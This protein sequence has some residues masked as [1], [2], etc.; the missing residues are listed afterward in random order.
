M[1]AYGNTNQ[2]SK[3]AQEMD[4][5]GNSVSIADGDTTSTTADHTD[6]GGAD[7]ST[8]TVDRT[9]TITN[10]GSLALNLTGTPVVAVGGTDAGD[11][12]V[13]A[14]P[15][16]PIASSGGTTTFTVRFDPSAVGARTATISITNNDSDENPYDFMIQGTGTAPEMNLKQGT[17]NIPDGGS[18]GFGSHLVNTDTDVT[19]TIE[20]TGAADL[21]LTILPI[22]VGGADAGQFSIQTQPVSPVTASGNTTFTVRFT[23]T[24][25]GTKT[26][27]ISIVNDDSD[28]NPYDLT[29][30]GTGIA[31][32]ITS[33]SPSSGYPGNS[34]SVTINGTNLSGATT[35]NFGSGITTNSFTV[36]S[37]TQ[38]TATIDISGSAVPGTRD[39]SVTTPGGTAT[40][41]GGFSVL[42]VVTYDEPS[43]YLKIN[44]LGTSQSFSTSHSGKVRQTVEITSTDG[45]LT[46][47][48]PKGTVARQ[49]NGNRLTT[50]G[51]S[52]KENP[53]PP[54][55]NS[56]II[57]LTYDFEP[58]GAT[59]DPPITLTFTYDPETLPEGVEEEDLV[60]AFYDEDTGSWIE[61]E[62][63]VDTDNHTITAL[64]S[65]FTNFAIIGKVIPPAAFTV[66]NL[67]V[68][69]EQIAPGE[70]VIITVSVANTGGMEGSYTAILE[71]NGVREETQSISIAAGG[72][73]RVDFTVSREEP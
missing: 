28:E 2:A 22:T 36:G 72:T 32:G 3:M 23:P 67:T 46:V 5:Y 53:P 38:I 9:F 51:V 55:E 63:V 37:S 52:V 44:L 18:Y 48:I 56:N 64:V 34:F 65:H 47:T 57:G 13:T 12:A 71:V 6:F 8:G 24:P 27:T 35:V 58:D 62:C 21:N 15:S 66:S 33:A 16:T 54:P 43:Y 69:P 17:T 11:F 50:F 49:E 26:A 59:F 42:E 39:I 4:V 70:V 45:L 1:G 19:F 30:T 40:L 60:L 29:L 7:I 14:Q 41:V 73:K 10:S 20:N 31:P 68:E 61:L 25:A